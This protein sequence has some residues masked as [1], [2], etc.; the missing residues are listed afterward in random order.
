MHVPLGPAGEGLYS[1]ATVG[2]FDVMAKCQPLVLEALPVALSAAL[3]QPG[4]PL[5]VCDFGAADGGTSL[6]MWHA[7][8]AAARRSQPDIDISIAFE[9]QA[10]HRCVHRNAAI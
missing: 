2:C 8:V 7:F 5:S 1:L 4:R 6:P 3:A 10:R 9:D